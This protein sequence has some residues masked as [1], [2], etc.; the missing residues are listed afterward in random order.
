MTLAVDKPQTEEKNSTPTC[1]KGKMV[2]SDNGHR[3]K[4]M[5]GC[6]PN[7]PMSV[8]IKDI[9]DQIPD[10][11]F[12]QNH[13]K[14]FYYLARDCVQLAVVCAAMYYG[15]LP[16]VDA[17]FPKDESYF[18]VATFLRASALFVGWNIYAFLNGVSATGIW[19][20][21][22]EC[23]HRAF[24]PKVWVNDAVGMVLHSALLVPYHSWR[25]S[26]GTHHKNTNHLTADTVFIP[27][28]RDEILRE[29]I[30]ESPIVHLFEIAIM[31]FVGWPGYLI[32]NVTGQNYGRRAN[33]F[34]P[35]SPIFRPFQA[36]DIA[37]SNI[38]LFVVAS[39]MGMAISRFGFVNVYLWYLAPYLWVNAWLVTI[40]FLQHSD[41]R[42]PHYTA[43]NFTF[44]RGA[45]A[46]IDRS[47]GWP[48]N[49]GLHHINDSHIQHHLFSS[50]PFYHAIEATRK[51]NKEILG[52][53]WLT[54]DRSLP[55]MIWDSWKYCRYVVPKEGVAW[56][57]R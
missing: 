39:L 11:Y 2:V 29:S 35:R 7:I 19:V 22:H 28:K 33:H 1:R 55:V 57:R 12:K 5:G 40:T 50:M 26:H 54:D 46:A 21:A 6:Q 8:T 56:Y 53:W 25:I 47:Y 23:G 17:S 15:Y 36:G 42:L 52:D 51:Y 43:E 9:K 48:L 13:W 20:L 16:F 18:S 38:G 49:W 24:S 27:Q 45:L 37:N 41:V 4:I 31:L 30:A 14:S 3:A 32:L 10:H 34:E 44:V